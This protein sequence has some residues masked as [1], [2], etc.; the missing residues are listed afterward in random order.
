MRAIEANQVAAVDYLLSASA[1]P[2][3]LDSF[4][5]PCLHR[6]AV[7]CNQEAGAAN[8]S[9]LLRYGAKFDA[10]DRHED[11]PLHVAC[12]VG[13]DDIAAILLAAGADV[14]PRNE[15]GCTPLIEAVNCMPQVSGSSA[16][17]TVRVLLDAGADPNL[18]NDAGETALHYACWRHDETDVVIKCLL[19]AGASPTIPNNAGKTACEIA[20][21][22]QH[23]ALFAGFA[24]VKSAASD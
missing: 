1:D 13:N 14:D 18:R 8:V 2:N 9:A 5:N 7:S 12:E 16:L 15:F 23:A 17:C 21:N 11:T 24:R 10:Q 20:A 22:G 19:A 3:S 6:A 4:Q